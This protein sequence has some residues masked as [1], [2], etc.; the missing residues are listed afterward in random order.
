LDAL[1]IALVAP[2]WGSTPPDTYGGIERQVY[3]LS[4]GLAQRGHHVTLFATGDSR[5][6]G[7]LAATYPISL[8]AAMERG[9]AYVYD[10]Y[11]SA[12]ISDVLRRSDEFDVIH[13]NV[14]PASVPYA[15]LVS[16]PTFHT[17]QTEITL[18]DIWLLE[19]YP[20][21]QIFAIGHNQI[22]TIPAV[23]RH[24]I[25]TIY[26]SIDFE[27]YAPTDTVRSHLLYLSRVAD[28]KGTR[29]AIQFARSVGLEIVVA[30]APMTPE[31]KIY[32]DDQ[33]SPLLSDASVH[34]VG[35]VNDVQKRALLASSMALV[36]PIKWREPFGLV[37][38]EAMAAGVPVLATNIGS[39][40]EIVDYGKT[41]YYADSVDGFPGL[42][43]RTL[44]LNP[45]EIRE[46]AKARFS[47]DVMIERHLELYHTAHT[48]GSGLS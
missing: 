23:R 1:R 42:L 46:W 45:S 12:H 30:G 24:S 36:F 21:A 20:S 29:E 33:V 41:G 10:N 14:G 26:S 32:F 6:T 5:T 4:E 7:R 25:P 44:A 39:V 35:P 8:N 48:T 37:M 3:L 18:D 47:H 31:E 19:R 22:E 28:H 9:E 34:Y 38:I 15:Q 2:L 11:I 27:S 40:P 13:F 16:A 43:E 17:I